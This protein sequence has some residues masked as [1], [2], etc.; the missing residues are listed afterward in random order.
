MR[1]T[2]E[3]AREALCAPLAVDDERSSHNRRERHFR[4]P[5]ELECLVHLEHIF[6]TENVT[7]FVKMA[8]GTLAA[9]GSPSPSFKGLHG[10]TCRSWE[11]PGR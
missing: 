5:V 6:Q 4:H 11:P 10:A 2:G 7:I 9:T 3:E 8:Y 1:S